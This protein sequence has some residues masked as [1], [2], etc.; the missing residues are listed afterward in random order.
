LPKGDTILIFAFGIHRD[1]KH[2]EE[3]ET[4]NPERFENADGKFPYAYIP[5][6]AG[7]RNCIGKK[8]LYLLYLNFFNMA[9]ESLILD[10]GKKNFQPFNKHLDC[11]NQNCSC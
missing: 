7:P 3:P 1:P 2:F 5:F 6:S 4:F 11:Q 10:C 8:N 9:T